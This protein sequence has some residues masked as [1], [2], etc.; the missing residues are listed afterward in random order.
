MSV[1]DLEARAVHL[2]T[3]EQVEGFLREHADCV[4]F[5]AGS[6]YRT[7]TALAAVSPVLAEHPDL[8]VGF[9]RVVASRQASQRVAELT[10][11]QHASPQVLLL[12]GGRV[13][14]ERDNWDISAAALG[15]ALKKP[16]GA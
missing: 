14:H 4:L 6:C 8:P 10:G 5:K 11:V 3:P 1:E 9:I 13:V 15:D 2:T 7:E 16:T 12:R